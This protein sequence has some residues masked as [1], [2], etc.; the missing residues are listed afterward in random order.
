[1]NRLPDRTTMSSQLS[2]ITRATLTVK[3]TIAL[4]FSIPLN[5]LGQDAG[6][7]PFWH[8]QVGFQFPYSERTDFRQEPSKRQYLFHQGRRGWILQSGKPGSR[9]LRGFC[10]RNVFD[11]AGNPIGNAGLITSTQTPS[12]QIQ[13]ALKLIW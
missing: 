1:M 13:F 9:E 7:K 2:P 10:L 12:R 4:A 8:G 3:L 11:S 6:K 5:A